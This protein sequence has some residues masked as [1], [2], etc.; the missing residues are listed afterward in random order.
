MEISSIL[1]QPGC[2]G[3]LV[4]P[5]ACI[6]MP[7]CQYPL[8]PKYNHWRIFTASLLSSGIFGISTHHTP[9]SFAQSFLISTTHYALTTYGL[10]QLKIHVM[11][12]ATALEMYLRDMSRLRPPWLGG[13]LKSVPREAIKQDPFPY[14]FLRLG[15]SFITIFTGIQTSSAL[16]VRTTQCLK[17][18]TPR[19]YLSMH[20]G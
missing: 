13:F 11:T 15:L 1:R 3:F 16:F 20:I 18:G 9:K 4:N 2:V 7:P 8:V 6:K 5:W 14:K 10:R 17:P 19:W 12:K